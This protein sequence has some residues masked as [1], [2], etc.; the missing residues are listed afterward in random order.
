MS[1]NSQPEAALLAALGGRCIVLIGMMGSGKTSVG[2]PLAACL[3]LDFADADTE[4]ET[5]HA[6]TIPEIFAR[7]GEPYFREGE[8]R[9]LARLLAQGPKVVAT[10]GG[11]FMNAATRA[12]I[13]EQGVSIWLKADLDVLIRRV[14]RRANRPLLQTPDSEG[15]LRKLIDDRYPTYALADVTVA[16]DDGPHEKVAA[17]AVQALMSYLNVHPVP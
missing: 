10:G 12:R 6:M 4:I 14:R 5:A 15:A 16:S 3:G 11:A 9:V 1:L 13:A 2:R 17:E 8:R 7:H